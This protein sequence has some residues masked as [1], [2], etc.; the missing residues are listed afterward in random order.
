MPDKKKLTISLIKSFSCEQ[1]EQVYIADTDCTGLMLRASRRSAKGH[2]TKSFVYYARHDG[3]LVNRKIEV[4]AD[5]SITPSGLAKARSIA[6]RWR[7]ECLSG[8]IPRA[9]AREFTF[10]DLMMAYCDYLSSEGKESASAVKNEVRKGIK[11]VSQWL[12]Q[13]KVSL[14]TFEDCN[15]LCA[16]HFRNHQRKAEKLRSYIKAAFNLATRRS[17]D[18]PKVVLD[19]GIEHNPV[20]N[21]SA[22]KRKPKNKK[23]DLTERDISVVRQYLNRLEQPRHNLL[24]LFLLLGGQRPAQLVRLTWNDVDTDSMLLTIADAKGRGGVFMHQVPITGRVLSVMQQ[25]STEGYLFSRTAGVEPIHTD[26]LRDAFDSVQE[27]IASDEIELSLP[28]FTIGSVRATVLTTLARHGVPKEVRSRFVS[29]EKSGVEYK[30][31]QSHDFLPEKRNAMKVW[32][33]VLI[34]GDCE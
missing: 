12:W 26:Y 18:S 1:G 7:Q 29:T 30:N 28:R 19:M 15:N 6:N 24:L 2:I 3:K 32:H 22:P 13:K 11:E 20:L 34:G 27:A 9:P 16:T 5:N 21:W 23:P 25:L 14:V 10:G 31:Y 33:R 8:G 4:P 17:M